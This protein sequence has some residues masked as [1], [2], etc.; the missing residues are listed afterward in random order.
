MA[1]TEPER[2]ET[3]GALAGQSSLRERPDFDQLRD[4]M[5]SCA[6]KLRT[7]TNAFSAEMYTSMFCASWRRGLPVDVAPDHADAFLV[8][9]A[10]CHAAETGLRSTVARIYQR[11]TVALLRTLAA[12]ADPDVA[13]LALTGL[14][15]P[16]LA[17]IELPEWSEHIGRA[18]LAFG[19][20]AEHELGDE[21]TALL[22][23]VYDDEQTH[24]V[25]IR[26]NHNLSGMATDIWAETD[27]ARSRAKLHTDAAADSRYRVIDTDPAALRAMCEAA[28]FVASEALDPPV[29]SGYR[30]LLTL[31]RARLRSLPPG[32]PLPEPQLWSELD[33]SDLIADFVTA[34]EAVGLTP[35]AAEA[36][37]TELVNYG[38]D[39]DR[40]QP[41][42]ISPAKLRMFL[43][44]W[45]P[46]TGLLPTH[47][48][49]DVP[50]VIAAWVGYAARRTGL[51]QQSLDETVAALAGI[52]DRFKAAY[53][54]RSRWS[55][56]R[57]GLEALLT[58]VDPAT[59]D[60]DDVFNRRIF[61]LPRLPDP[62]FDPANPDAFKQLLA[63][64]HPTQ[65][66][67]DRTRTGPGTNLTLHTMIA[68]Q[69]WA[70]E[71]PE[72]WSA[73]QRLLDQGLNRNTVLRVVGT[74]LAGQLQRKPQNGTPYNKAAYAA[75]LDALDGSDFDDDL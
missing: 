8:D 10:M 27:G 12:V 30:S 17:G 1:A 28:I 57:H 15:D 37:A 46:R 25:S 49:D 56:Q 16:A 31:A 55:P 39:H 52:T 68:Q 6:R 36:I 33:R 24:G 2:P 64:E 19:V 34:P 7:L 58:G 61:A 54:D 5:R 40:G 63:E 32:G 29:T 4:D 59:T 21:T 22:T 72:L 14:A 23:F 18:R 13:D 62:E 41:L 38:A 35:D 11:E 42:R 65:S 3:G 70:N 45:L 9:I 66:E 50:G 69:L 51:S 53:E 73:V 60:I 44:G 26:I 47:Y 75:A 74:T 43:L 48:L 20:L 71:P 67:G